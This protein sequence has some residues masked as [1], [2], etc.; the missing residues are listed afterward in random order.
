MNINIKNDSKR[1]I[2]LIMQLYK[3]HKLFEVVSSQ[4]KNTSEKDQFKTVETILCFNNSKLY[5]MF[6][7]QTYMLKASYE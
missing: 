2:N 3:T 1:V 5:K 6:K 4:Y 7:N